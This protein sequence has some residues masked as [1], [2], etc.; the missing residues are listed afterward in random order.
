M[1]RLTV[2][3]KPGGIARIMLNDPKRRNAIDIALALALDEALLAL[4]ADPAVRVIILGASGPDFC[5]G[6]SLA[7]DWE[8]DGRPLPEGHALLSTDGIDGFSAF[9]R[10]LFFDMPERWRNLPKPLIA[11]VQGH[12]IAGGLAVALACDLIVAAEDARFVDPTVALGACGPEHFAYPWDM[13][14]REAKYWLLTGA[15]L[16]AMNALR[17]G[18]VCEVHAPEELT[19]AAEALARRIA[20]KPAFAVRMTKEAINLAADVGGRRAGMQATFS[21]HQLCHAENLLRHGL[22]VVP[23]TLSEKA[24]ASVRAFSRRHHL[25]PNQT[26]E[27]HE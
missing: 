3:I 19:D 4:S 26:G 11:A 27:D 2:D 17:I 10:A 13:T 20:A 23:T 8:P 6:H 1:N 12:C 7:D 21:L 14:A 22:P 24:V 18:L 5:A 15:P 25:V 16:E 9:E